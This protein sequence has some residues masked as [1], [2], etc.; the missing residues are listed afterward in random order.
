MGLRPWG[1]PFE[2][3]GG[4]AW[5]DTLEWTQAGWRCF[6]RTLLSEWDLQHVLEYAHL[7]EPKPWRPKNDEEEVEG[8]EER[9]NEI[10]KR[11]AFNFENASV[12]NY[13]A[14]GIPVELCGDSQVVVNWLVGQYVCTTEV[15]CETIAHIQSILYRLHLNYRVNMRPPSW[16]LDPWKWFYREGNERADAETWKARTGQ[17]HRTF[18][19][20]IHTLRR[21]QI[22]GIRGYF[23][24]GRSSHGVGIGWV[25]DLF[26]L[27]LPALQHSQGSWLFNIASEAAAIPPTCTVSQA[28]LLASKRLA[29]GVEHLLLLCCGPES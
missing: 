3:V 19:P 25:I 26:V 28:E 7:P 2:T 10:A 12:W 21:E 8:T 18:D 23:D 4:D 1:L 22:K 20:C 11:L 14:E 13:E 27:P 29:E 5:Y 24:G 6:I 15:Y 9:N 17:N 16:G